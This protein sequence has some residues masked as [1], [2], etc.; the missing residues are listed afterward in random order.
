MKKIKLLKKIYK[1]IS[2]DIKYGQERIK[3]LY[4]IKKKKKSQLKKGDKI[5]LSTQNFKTI[6]P[7]QKLD[8][9]K[10]GFFFIKKQKE[11]ANYKLDFPKKIKIYPIFY[12]SLLEL[13]N[14]EILIF[15]KLPK[16][17]PKNKYKIKK[18]IDYNHKN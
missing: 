17:S 3:L 15:I 11:N 1:E 14:Q 16:L 12:I 4:N 8:H 13:A 10:I 5:Y 7:S 6:R 18:I 9:K 2:R